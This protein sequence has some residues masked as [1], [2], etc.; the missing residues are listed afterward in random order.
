MLPENV[1]WDEFITGKTAGNSTVARDAKE[2][3]L[4]D[5]LLQAIDLASTQ[6][7]RI[8]QAEKVREQTLMEVLAAAINRKGKRC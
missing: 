5:L 1:T 4:A 7:G 6:R 8:S 3:S 2:A